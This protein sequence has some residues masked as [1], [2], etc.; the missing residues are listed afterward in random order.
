MALKMKVKKAMPDNFRSE[1]ETKI[2][3]KFANPKLLWEALQGPEAA[4]KKIGD[5]KTEDGNKKM[6][7]LGD[8]YDSA[9]R[10]LNEW[11]ESDTS[12]SK[13]LS[14]STTPKTFRYLFLEHS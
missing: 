7:M 9:R 1:F 10:F 13:P 4:L 12:R 14:P 2:G 8:L 3:R 6:A 11:F 5:R